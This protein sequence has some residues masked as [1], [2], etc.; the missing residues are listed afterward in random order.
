MNFNDTMQILTQHNF[1]S[2]RQFQKIRY[3]ASIYTCLRIGKI[4]PR[5][6]SPLIRISC[7]PSSSYPFPIWHSLTIRQYDIH[8]K[9]FPTIILSCSRMIDLFSKSEKIK[10]RNFFNIITDYSPLTPNLQDINR[11]NQ[12]ILSLLIL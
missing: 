3:E 6:T 4:P 8:V 10:S 7:E 9:I 2:R 11:F 1:P 12:L 5:I